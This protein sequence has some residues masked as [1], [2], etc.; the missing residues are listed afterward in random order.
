MIQALRTTV[1]SP[2][3]AAMRISILSLVLAFLPWSLMAQE[4]DAPAE[5]IET[6]Q[7][8]D[9][10]LTAVLSANLVELVAD[11]DGNMVE[12]LVI[13]DTAVPGDIIQY[14]GTYENTS[15]EPLIGLIINGPIP[16]GT[17]YLGGSQSASVDAVFEVLIEGE[18][19]QELPAYRTI[20]DENG[21]EQQIEAT[22]ADFLQLRWRLG[23]PLEPDTSAISVYRVTV[24][25]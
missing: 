6:E 10:P 1:T 11:E 19:W 7:A 21:E 23:E 22:A 15:Q 5:A 12:T 16:S 25:R 13:A 9:A 14:T 20:T 8:E 17:R 2:L 4:G 24:N 3:Q 18:D